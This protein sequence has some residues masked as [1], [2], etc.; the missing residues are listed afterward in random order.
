[1]SELSI[2]ERRIL[3]NQYRI[4]AKV[5]PEN[6]AFYGYDEIIEILE[7]GFE[8]QYGRVLNRLKENRLS[9]EQCN[10]VEETLVMSSTLLDS[11]EDRGIGLNV[12]RFVE[13]D[14][15]TEH[16]HLSYAKFLFERNPGGYPGIEGV[17]DSNSSGRVEKYRAMIREWKASDTP[18]KLSSADVSRI[19]SAK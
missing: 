11:R 13:F 6:S 9:V 7:G 8:S 10:L 15:N 17:V 2:L 3:S 16:D 18:S 4:L 19:L 12:D 5:D 1:M 14:A